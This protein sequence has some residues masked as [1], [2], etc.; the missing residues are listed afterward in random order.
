LENEELMKQLIRQFIY[1]GYATKEF[2][3]FDKTWVFRTLSP[4]EHDDIVTFVSFLKSEDIIKQRTYENKVLTKALLSINGLTIEEEQSEKLFDKMSEKMFKILY[5]EY[6]ELEKLQNEALM[7]EEIIKS[8]AKPSFDRIKFL[9]MQDAHA[10]PTEQR[11]KDMNDYQW[12]WYW[13]NMQEKMNDDET[14]E[15]AK[16]D[17][18]CMFV[19][20][21][22][23]K[24]I[25]ESES[26][27]KSIQNHGG[28]VE[29][30]GN[31]QITYGSTTVDDDFDMKL[32]AM[33]EEGEEF[34][35]LPSSDQKGDSNETPEQFF[36]R[37]MNNEKY[38]NQYNEMHKK[39][40][41][42]EDFDTITPIE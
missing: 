8:F 21:E 20:P 32:K 2:E 23:W 41:Q 26:V 13:Y 9:V 29:M 11:V 28:H 6:T 25:K 22:L 7:H 10:L 24:K 12:L 27:N 14:L 38:V 17:Y 37:V 3:K 31:T 1:Q 33:M 19:N 4:Q 42:E 36:D 5:K 18:L 15:K 16:R 30:N 40:K 35:E 39:D 34:V